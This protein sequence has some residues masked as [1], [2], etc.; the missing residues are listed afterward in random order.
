MQV[1]IAEWTRQHPFRASAQ[2]GHRRVP[3]AGGYY[4]WHLGLTNHARDVV[5]INQ[6]KCNLND[7]LETAPNGIF[8]LYL[9]PKL[10]KLSS[11]RL[12]SYKQNNKGRIM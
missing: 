10:D 12:Q 4:E 3:S 7:N 6:S 5:L 2:N 9:M 8:K 1:T 11:N